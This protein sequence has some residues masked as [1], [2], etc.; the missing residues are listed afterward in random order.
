MSRMIKPKK[1]SRVK[2]LYRCWIVIEEY[3]PKTDVYQ[4]LEGEVAMCGPVFKSL[5]R[6]REHKD[7]VEQDQRGVVA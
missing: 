1:K 4:D 3:N 7:S 6:A 5:K 2:K